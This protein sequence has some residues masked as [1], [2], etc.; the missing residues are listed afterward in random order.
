MQSP[1]LKQE[2]NKKLSN[3]TECVDCL[4][5]TF[6]S[7]L[8]YWSLSSR[9]KLKTHHCIFVAN[10]SVIFACNDKCSVFDLLIPVQRTKKIV[11]IQTTR[12]YHLN[13]QQL[14][15]FEILGALNISR[16]HLGVVLNAVFQSTIFLTIILKGIGKILIK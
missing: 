16:L 7:Y 15:L 11:N 12:N 4:K 8:I 6:F 5:G 14:T 2:W 13:L 9:V 3:V 10:N 1:W